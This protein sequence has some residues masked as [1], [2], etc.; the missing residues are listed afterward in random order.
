MSFRQPVTIYRYSGTGVVGGFKVDGAET[1]FTIRASIQPVRPSD[2]ET[3]PEGRR[4]GKN[5]FRLYTN[6]TLQV[7][8]K[9]DMKPDQ[10]ELFGERYEVIG[11]APWQNNVINHHK[12]IVMKVLES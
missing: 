7:V 8:N 3:L 12:Y 9:G 4:D 1:S 5:A 10:A 2:L 6:S 11:H